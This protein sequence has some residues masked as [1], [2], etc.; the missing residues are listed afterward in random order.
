VFIDG[1]ALTPSNGMRISGNITL[2]GNS[3]LQQDP[4]NDVIL[5]GASTNVSVPRT[6][7]KNQSS[8]IIFGNIVLDGSAYYTTAADLDLTGAF[9]FLDPGSQ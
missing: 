3:T 2:T 4:G 7:T 1:T 9:I 8:S 5:Y 6:I